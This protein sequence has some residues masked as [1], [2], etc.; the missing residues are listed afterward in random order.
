MG[1]IDF[2]ILE[3]YLP[4]FFE[5]VKWTVFVSFIT[6]CLGVLIGSVLYV[7][8][9]NK[10]LK[11]IAISYI[12]IIRGTPL[13]LQIMIAY[14]GLTV[15]GIDLSALTACILALSINSAAY[16][17]EIIRAGIDAV[18]KGQMEAARSLG[19]TQFQAMKLI[20]VPQA[21][22]NILPAIGNEFVTVIKES[23]MASVIGVNELMYAAKVVSGAT[24]KS[25]EAYICVAVFYFVLTFTLGRTLGFIE[26][27]MK[28]GDSR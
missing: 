27:R 3:K 14:S 1:G 28:A 20:I 21:I 13:L 10:Y 11:F 15:F 22:K 8:R 17:S 7:L 24:Y 2:S 18:D 19:M 9:K 16:V 25:F 12:E 26:R 4:L 6:V 5:G 23:S